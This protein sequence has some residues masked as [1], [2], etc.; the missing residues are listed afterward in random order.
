M[1]TTTKASKRHGANKAVISNDPGAPVRAALRRMEAIEQEALRHLEASLKELRRGDQAP[2]RAL[3]LI[4]QLARLGVRRL[5]EMG[6]FDVIYAMT[7][8]AA[9]VALSCGTSPEQFVAWLRAMA[10]SVMRTTP[11]TKGA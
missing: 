10:A 11:T 4:E 7:T 8:A 9:L 2:S 3:D 5:P 6:D 1:K